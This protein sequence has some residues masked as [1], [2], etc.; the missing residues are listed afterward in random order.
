MVGK[1]TDKS[2]LLSR[3]QSLL[4]TYQAEHNVSAE[5]VLKLLEEETVPISIFT[6]RALGILES[7]VKYLREEK[8]YS[9]AKIA[10]L[11]K[12]DNRTVWSTYEQSKRKSPEPMHGEGI[13]IPVS[14]FADREKG[15]L[16][17]I[18]LHFRKKGMRYSEIGRLL[19]RDTR[20]IW[21]V[22]NR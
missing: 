13:S 20:T 17:A 12:R 15:V 4:H 19:D 11:L 5:Q 8:S 7:L 14:I 6:N 2:L 1:E 21:T 16:E 18:V 10:V 3:F 22:G 9:L